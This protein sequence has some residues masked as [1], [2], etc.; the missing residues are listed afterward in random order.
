[1]VSS[2]FQMPT[3]VVFKDGN[4]INELVGADQ[5]ASGLR[6]SLSLS[7]VCSHVTDKP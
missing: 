7:R 5:N 4:K 3:F 2:T 1:M 6:V